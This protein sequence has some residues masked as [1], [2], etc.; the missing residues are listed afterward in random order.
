MARKREWFNFWCPIGVGL[1]FCGAAMRWP[2]IG[3]ELIALG[4]SVIAAS[5]AHRWLRL[6]PS[7]VC[8][9]VVGGIALGGFAI[10]DRLWPPPTPPEVELALRL[11]T[12]LAENDIRDKAISAVLQQWERLKKAE[13]QNE[14]FFGGVTSAD[15]QAISDQIQ[16]DLL[17][18]QQSARIMGFAQGRGLIIQTAPNTFRVVFP[19]V[20]RIVPR[21]EV[22]HTPPGVE[23]KVVES[24]RAGA[25]IIYSPTTTPVLMTDIRAGDIAFSADF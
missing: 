9:I 19:V 4:L 25:T 5:I 14:R 24:S 16:T 15:R 8:G 18:I 7:V 11:Q 17:A 13:L 21:L 10:H 2:D 6:V 22:Y 3:V 23:P 1:L 20:M 12:I